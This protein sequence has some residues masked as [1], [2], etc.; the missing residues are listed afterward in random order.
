MEKWASTM[1]TKGCHSWVRFLYSLSL[2]FP[3]TNLH[4]EVKESGERRDSGS[5]SGPAKHQAVIALDIASWEELIDLYDITSSM[6]PHRE[7]EEHS[8]VGAKGWYA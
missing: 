5:A 1:T 6:I 7:E 8:S 4:E 2:P 3:I